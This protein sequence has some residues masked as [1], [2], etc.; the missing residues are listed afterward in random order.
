MSKRQRKASL[1]ILALAAASVL[2]FASPASAVSVSNACTNSVTA[3][4]TEVDTNTVGDAP[5][6]PVTG[7]N[8][9]SL[10]GIQQQIGVPGTVFVAGYN[11]GLLHT[12]ANTVP[13]SLSTVIEATNTT[14][15]QQ[16]TPTVGGS[17]PNGSVTVTTTITDPD[18][19]AGTGDEV[20]T[21]ATGT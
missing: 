15:G 8:T 16:T 14:Q 19:I 1:L 21:P 7:G 13:V 5:P 3:N 18:G 6:G 17:P 11:L 2:T 10:T 4:N 9:I 20:A 12:G